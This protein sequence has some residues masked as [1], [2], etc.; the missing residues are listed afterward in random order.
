[1][2]TIADL[3]P[4]QRP[5]CV[6][7]WCDFLP[8]PF[9]NEPPEPAIG[10]IHTIRND[11]ALVIYAHD[12]HDYPHGYYET[13]VLAPRFDLPRA[14]TPD[15]APVPGS[16]QAGMKP[17][18]APVFEQDEVATHRRYVTEWEPQ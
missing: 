11:E 2:T 7:M 5:E 12:T 15:G 4:E 3:T 10:I 17:Q 9:D 8:Y 6:G 1:M 14:W 13:D 16:W 18:Q